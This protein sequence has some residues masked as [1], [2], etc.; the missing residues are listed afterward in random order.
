V[1]DDANQEG[2]EQPSPHFPDAHPS[3]ALSRPAALTTAARGHHHGQERHIAFRVR[4]PRRASELRRAYL[5]AV[6][7]DCLVTSECRSFSS[8]R[9]AFPWTVGLVP[10]DL[11]SAVAPCNATC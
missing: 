8:A 10:S 9:A 5:A 1:R 7:P 6:V 3:L 2:T 11:A 4:L